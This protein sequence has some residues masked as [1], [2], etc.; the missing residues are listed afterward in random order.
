MGLQV[1]IFRFSAVDRLNTYGGRRVHPFDKDQ[2]CDLPAHDAFVAD[3][4]GLFA[5]L[6]VNYIADLCF[7]CWGARVDY[8]GLRF[9]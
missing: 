9:R 8:I 3:S 5:V 6:E 2:S 4:A 1:P 7:E